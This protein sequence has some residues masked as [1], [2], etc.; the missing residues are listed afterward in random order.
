MADPGLMQI[1]ERI[2]KSKGWT[3]YQLAQ[4]LGISQ[5]QL[6]HYTQKSIST[7]ELML[8]KLFELSGLS[9]D[10]FWSLLHKE[11]EVERQKRVKAKI[12]A[13]RGK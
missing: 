6:K 2:K 10:E 3:D 9:L 7:R 4:A 12:D 13:L 11:A 5:T 1:Y 8:V